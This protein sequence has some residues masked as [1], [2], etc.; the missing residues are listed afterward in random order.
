M[1][2]TPFFFYKLSQRKL[3]IMKNKREETLN[4]KWCQIISMPQVNLRLPENLRRSAEKYA[5]RYGYRNLQELVTQALREKVLEENS[6]KETLEIMKN[7][8]L[9]KSLRRSMRDVKQGKVITFS[10][11]QELR[12]RYK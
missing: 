1:E 7:K 8:E 12:K 3:A 4:T 6:L 9:M 2:M 10:S 5:E 11:L